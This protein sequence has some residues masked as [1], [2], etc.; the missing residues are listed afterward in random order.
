MSD[1][2]TW[3]FLWR[4]EWKKLWVFFEKKNIF[5]ICFFNPKI[6][7]GGFK[8][9]NRF[10]FF[11]FFWFLFFSSLK[12]DKDNPMTSLKER[13]LGRTNSL[14]LLM[15][16]DLIYLTVS[17]NNYHLRIWNSSCSLPKG[18]LSSIHWKFVPA[19]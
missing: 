10:F 12:S 18:F 3:K 11:N 17:T 8:K 2:E 19:S 1:Q 13:L 16:I 4:A 5:K 9:S 7:L 14:K 6:S 15:M